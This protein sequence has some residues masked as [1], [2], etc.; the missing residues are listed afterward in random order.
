MSLIQPNMPASININQS[1]TVPLPES[2]FPGWVN[3]KES[4]W[5]TEFGAVADYNDQD[6]SLSTDNTLAFQQALDKAGEL[7]LPVYIPPGRYWCAGEVYLPKNY[8]PNMAASMGKGIHIYGAGMYDSGII[9]TGTEYFISTKHDMAEVFFVNDFY[10][11][12]ANG[13]GIHL[14]QGAHQIFERFFSSACGHGKNGV[15]I[16]GNRMDDEPQ[17]G[18]GSYVISMRNCRFW[19]E[20]QYNGSGVRLEDI[21]LCTTIDTCFFSNLVPDRAHLELVRCNGVVIKSTAF[22]RREELGVPTSGLI[23]IENSHGITIEGS[24]PEPFYAAF[25]DIFDHSSNIWIMNTRADLYALSPW[26]EQRG[27]AVR[28]DPASTRS[29]NIVVENYMIHQSNH[30]GSQRGHLILDPVGCVTVRSFTDMTP[31]A[32]LHAQHA[33]RY[34][35][36]LGDNGSN[37]IVNPA[38]FSDKQ[39][40]VPHGI[41][42]LSGTWQFDQINPYYSGCRVRQTKPNELGG[43]GY[44]IP[45]RIRLKTVEQYFKY[46][47]YT[48]VIYGR[49]RTGLDTQIYVDVDGVG[50]IPTPFRL[51]TGDDRFTLHVKI[52]M[53]KINN[54]LSLTV[55]DPIDVDIYGI[56]LYPYHTTHPSYGS[57]SLTATTLSIGRRWSYGSGVPNPYNPETDIVPYENGE[58]FWNYNPSVGDHIGMVFIQGVGWC[59]FGLIEP[60]EG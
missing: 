25:V 35:E 10:I 5:I 46:P 24:H 34:V 21:L 39:T 58:I 16:E 20:Q 28:V 42:Q 51:P 22:E 38:L 52:P 47:Y 9:Y 27:Y 11:H 6:P 3:P 53:T 36:R 30:E 1:I 33:K 17:T 37:L 26:N 44:S 49:N 57:E 12:H 55:Y 48:M 4:I 50:N 41:E 23:R 7:Q 54:L 13:G 31:Y 40:G 8:R 60:K 32:N 15:Y 59:K 29:E 18:Y 19:N 45:Y 2:S 43:D 56:F 14:P